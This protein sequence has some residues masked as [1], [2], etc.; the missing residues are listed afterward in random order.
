MAANIA[1]ADDE[2]MPA[3]RIESAGTIAECRKNLGSMV[4]PYVRAVLQMPRDH[5]GYASSSSR[6]FDGRAASQ[7]PAGLTRL[8]GR[9]LY[10]AGFLRILAVRNELAVIRGIVPI[11]INSVNFQ[12][13]L[14]SISPCPLNEERGVF[15]PFWANSYASP[16]VILEIFHTRAFAARLHEAKQ[17]I[18][19]IYLSIRIKARISTTYRRARVAR[20]AD[21]SL[22]YDG[23]SPA[24]RTRLCK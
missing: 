6:L 10:S 13:L 1:R 14:P 18:E 9:G 17:F 20:L 15:A 3:G 24:I 21:F 23:N 5:V 2:S 11:T 22:V 8:V 7:K 12:P 4:A 19:R 16:P